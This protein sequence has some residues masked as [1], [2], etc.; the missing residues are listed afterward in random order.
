[1]IRKKRVQY[2]DDNMTY[3]KYKNT[4]FLL[5]F[6]ANIDPR[7]GVGYTDVEIKGIIA[8]IPGRWFYFE[9]RLIY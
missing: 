1:M 4:S 5:C 8:S 2:C 3:A 6:A 7:E 9:E